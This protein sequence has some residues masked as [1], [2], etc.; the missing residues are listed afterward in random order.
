MPMS[1]CWTMCTGNDSSCAASGEHTAISN[2]A[3]P[4]RKLALRR[5]LQFL[6]RL[7]RRATPV[8][9]SA[10]A[11]GSVAH[12]AGVLGQSVSQ[13]RGIH[14]SHD[15]GLAVTGCLA[16]GAHQHRDPNEQGY[17]SQRV[18]HEVVRQDVH[19]V[20]DLMKPE[21]LVLQGSVVQ[22]EATQPEKEARP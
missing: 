13:P 11:A 17:G 6:P 7:R 22:L 2:V 14:S 9:Y 15:D 18:P 16:P 20:A 5:L 1:R 12:A 4:A 8:A 10:S 3:H 21:D 19:V